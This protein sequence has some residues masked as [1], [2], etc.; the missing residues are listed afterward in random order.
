MDE[1]CRFSSS[2]K[3]VHK[4][5]ANDISGRPRIFFL[6][7]PTSSGKSTLVNALLGRSVLPTSHN[8]TTSTLCEI[9]QGAKK[10][11]VMHLE[12]RAGAAGEVKVTHTEQLLDMESERER[13]AFVS[14]VNPDRGELAGTTATSCNRA[15]VYWPSQFLQEFT[16]I[17]SPGVTENDDLSPA[18]RQITEQCQKDTACGFMYVIDATQSAEVGAQV[19]G[20]LA[21][22]ARGTK[23]SPPADSALFVLNK[24]DQFLEKYGRKESERAS[25]EY[26]ERL[27]FELGRRWRGFKSY[28]V[29]KMNSKLAGLAQ[30][31]GVLTNDMK[32]LCEGIS[33]VLPRG[34]NNM[35]LKALKRPIDLLDYVEQSIEA[36]LREFKLPDDQRTRK[37]DEN[38]KRLVE[39]QESLA[40]G[41]IAKLRRQ[42][43]ER[44]D[45]LTHDVAEHL[46]T[47]ETIAKALDWDTMSTD[48]NTKNLFSEREVKE[49]VGHRLAKMICHDSRVGKVRYAIGEEVGPHVEEE[50]QRLVSFRSEI[51]TAKPSLL[52]RS[53][54]A[55]PNASG[56]SPAQVVGMIAALA[57]APISVPIYGIVKLVQLIRD[58]SF[59]KVVETAYKAAVNEVSAGSKGQLRDS[60]KRVIVATSLTARIVYEGFESMVKEIDDELSARNQRR[61]KD[62]PKYRKL[63]LLSQQMIGKASTFM[64]ELGIEDYVEGDIVW[65][66]PCIPVDS[67]VFGEV[68]KVELARRKDVALKV[69]KDPISE[70]NAEEFLRELVI[71]RNLTGKDSYVVEF[72]G[73]VRV[74]RSPLKLALAF[75]WCSG[76]NLAD[77]MF[78]PSSQFVPGRKSGG[79]L[80]ARR[81]LLQLFSGV[82]FL[83]GENL[84][85]RDI[86][87]ENILLTTDKEVRIADLGLAKDLEEITGTQCGTVLYMAPEVMVRNAYGTSA[88]IFSVGI[89]MWELWHGERAYVNSGDPTLGHPA[90]FAMKV[91]AGNF[92]P[93]GFVAAE[94]S[95]QGA[96]P[97]DAAVDWRSL[98]R[99][100]WDSSASSR[101]TAKEAR[102]IVEKMPH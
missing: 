64:L 91:F 31:L 95:G 94:Y 59:R 87:P 82:M 12:T 84:V 66:N 77:E 89:I 2:K 98:M 4:G 99:R 78:G 43:D 38:A 9:K 67:G 3:I 34:M 60:V 50:L 100:C 80:H 53:D 10:K 32:N 52:P 55:L 42:I 47:K 21:A 71:S 19:G 51:F 68:F 101:P 70:E 92:R 96:D 36:T 7:G 15:E 63:L 22:M 37:R 97:N 57:I 46:K 5:K 39:F 81:I 54:D 28:Q 85:H 16:L 45:D 86:K 56:Y 14:L 72:Y 35:I 8:A 25:K 93:P 1:R 79:Y 49:L 11:A 73:L 83:H 30:E 17:D 75:E 62:L 18:S 90:L 69:L 33:D 13:K 48:K 40:S 6:E 88:D 61:E 24:W 29:I 44:L 74:Q 23:T 102:S 41:K 26:L 58:R 20:L 76:G 65:P 27:Y